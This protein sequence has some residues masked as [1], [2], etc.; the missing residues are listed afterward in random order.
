MLNPDGGMA[1]RYREL[2]SDPRYLIGLL[3]QAL[4][5]LLAA[6]IPPMDATAELLAEAVADAITHRRRTCPAC[7][8]DGSGI[9]AKCWPSWLQANAYEGLALSLGIICEPRPPQLRLAGG[10]K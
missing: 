10:S 8:D 9:C 1:E 4:T 5:A 7:P 2:A 3:S 6:D